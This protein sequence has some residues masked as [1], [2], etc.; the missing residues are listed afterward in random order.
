MKNSERFKTY[1]L[2]DQVVPEVEV[3]DSIDEDEINQ[4]E[5]MEIQ[6]INE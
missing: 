5:I 2:E 3:V 6:N 1:G 4:T